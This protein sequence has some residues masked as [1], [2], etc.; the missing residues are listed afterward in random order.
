MSQAAAARLREAAEDYVRAFAGDGGRVRGVQRGPAKH[1]AAV[2]Q[3]ISALNESV[4]EP[5]PTPGHRAAQQA[6]RTGTDAFSD[7]AD[8]ARQMLVNDQQGEQ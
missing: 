7:A 1:V 3:L 4:A 5:E 6:R 8:R 2:Q